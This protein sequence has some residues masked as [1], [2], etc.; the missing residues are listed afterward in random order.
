MTP[1]D[2]RWIPARRC[3]GVLAGLALVLLGGCAAPPPPPPLPH[4]A[5]VW[6]R[7]WDDALRAALRDSR[8]DFAGLRVLALQRDARGNWIETAPDLA[9]LRADGRALVLVARLDGSAPDWPGVEL[10]AR[11]N[12]LL[13]RWHEAGLA[14]AVEIDHDCAS[15]RLAGYAQQLTALRRQLP[16]QTRLSITAL[17]AWTAASD[18]PALLAAV[19]ESVLQVH[20]VASPAAGLFDAAQALRWSQ[21]WAQRSRKPFLLALP[22]YGARLKLA[23]DG[24]VE[25]V[26]SEQSLPRRSVGER[27]LKVDPAAVA[28]LL[29]QLQTQRPAQLAGVIW[30][31]LPRAGDRRAWSLPTLQAVIHAQPLRPRLRLQQQAQADGAIDLVLDNEGSLDAPLPRYWRVQGDCPA[32][33]AASGYVFERDGAGAVFRL[34]DADDLRAGGRRP[35]GWLRCRGGAPVL[36]QSD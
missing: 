12:A 35:L 6:Q 34:A 8:A 13:Q 21:A 31:R 1:A 29:R 3:R 4:S 32:G 30:F 20:A 14:A 7:Q 11:L 26:E 18:L 19:D 24:A 23:A 15:A 2:Q 5:Y 25:A 9:A 22:A 16:A 10:A 28:G 33:D 27:E 17:P 36:T